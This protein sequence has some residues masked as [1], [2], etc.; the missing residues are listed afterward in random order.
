[1]TRTDTRPLIAIPARFAATTSALRYA[2]EVNAR[3]L[4]EA[5]WWAGVSR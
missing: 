2:A 4:V 3:A 5:V 1:M